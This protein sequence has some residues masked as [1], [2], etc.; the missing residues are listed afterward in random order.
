MSFEAGKPILHS[1]K[2]QNQRSTDG[3]S[4]IELF[5]KVETI[6]LNDSHAPQQ[7]IVGALVFSWLHCHAYHG[8]LIRK[9]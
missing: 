9:C 5:Q 4:V 1:I 7:E 6:P 2:R 8:K 3:Q